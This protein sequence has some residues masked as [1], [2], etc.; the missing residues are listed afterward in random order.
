MRREDEEEFYF[1]EEDDSI[2]EVPTE[3]KFTVDNIKMQTLRNFP[4]SRLED[5]FDIAEFERKLRPKHVRKIKDAILDNMMY[6]NIVTAIN[7]GGRWRIIDGQ[8]RLK[9]LSLAHKEDGLKKFTIIVREL[10]GED[11]R[12]IYR[13][14]NKGRPLT[15]DDILRS[16]NDGSLRYFTVF[17]P[18]CSVYSKRDRITYAFLAY[19]LCH[20][21]HKK[22]QFGK[23]DVLIMVK[24]V[25]DEEI[26]KTREFLKIVAETVGINRSSVYFKSVVFWNLIR[27]YTE[28][29]DNSKFDRLLKKIVRDRVIQE[30]SRF[31]RSQ[32]NLNIIYQ[33]IGEMYVNVRKKRKKRKGKL[34]K[35]KVSKVQVKR[36]KAATSQ[37][38]TGK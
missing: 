18:W 9:A 17:N 1:D 7:D 25:K 14:I 32:L 35:T 20:V 8:H 38:K 10:K 3:E 27:I 6:D 15:M 12:K 33:R 19:A 4:L 31:G 22:P 13:N 34:R 2:F 11:A 16:M 21:R 30:N 36:R 28:E 23:D 26:D 29:T 24:S 37:R 5:K